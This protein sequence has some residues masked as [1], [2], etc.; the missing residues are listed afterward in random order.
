VEEDVKNAGLE[1]DAYLESQGQT[2]DDFHTELRTGAEQAVKS[3]LILDAIAD[4]EEIGVSDADLSDQVVRQAQRSG[5]SPEVLAQ[6]IMQS[7]QLGALVG[8]VRRGKALALVTQN[9]QITDASGRP[10]SLDALREQLG[11]GQAGAGET[12]DETDD[13]A[14]E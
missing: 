13:D 1:L 3:Q 12:D 4:K 6:Q 8:D 10:V 2:H 14:A 9:A 5:V 11:G 7:G